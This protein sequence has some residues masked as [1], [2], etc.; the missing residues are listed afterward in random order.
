MSTIL[1]VITVPA[2]HIECMLPVAQRLL[3]D[4]HQL[5]NAKYGY[6]PGE[7]IPE[8]RTAA[9][10]MGQAAQND[11]HETTLLKVIGGAL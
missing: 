3:G 4:G 6:H 1:V 8:L 9:S 11:G 5:G 2:G 10:P 7:R